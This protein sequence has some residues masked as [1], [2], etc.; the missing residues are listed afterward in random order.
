[1]LPV[2]PVPHTLGMTAVQRLDARRRRMLALHGSTRQVTTPQRLHSGGSQ[3]LPF[4]LRSLSLLASLCA[5]PGGVPP[6]LPPAHLRLDVRRRRMALPGFCF[7]LRLRLRSCSSLCLRLS[8]SAALALALAHVFDTSAIV[9]TTC[10]G[11]D[12]SGGPVLH[13]ALFTPAPV[14]NASSLSGSGLRLD[15][16]RGTL[17]LCLLLTLT[18]A[19]ALALLTFT[20]QPRRLCLCLFFPSPTLRLAALLL[21]LQLEAALLCCVATCASACHSLNV[22]SRC[23]TLHTFTFTLFTLTLFTFTCQPCRLCLFFLLPSPTLRLAALLLKLQLEAALFG[24]VTTCVS[25]CHSLNAHSR[26][27]NLV[28]FGTFVVLLFLKV[29]VPRIGV[30]KSFVGV[31]IIVVPIAS[32]LTLNTVT[33]LC[34]CR[35]CFCFTPPTLFRFFSTPPAP[36]HRHLK[37]PL[38]L[39][40]RSA[41]SGSALDAN[42]CPPLL[43]SQRSGAP[44]LFLCFRARP[45]LSRTLRGLLGATLLFFSPLTGII[46][47][48]GLTT[49]RDTLNAHRRQ[50]VLLLLQRVVQLE[51]AAPSRSAPFL[52]FCFRLFLLLPSQF[53]QALLLLCFLAQSSLRFLRLS[54]LLPSKISET[55]P[56]LSFLAQS[57]C[58]LLLRLLL[59]SKILQ[60]LPLP[61]TLCFSAQPFCLRLFLLLPSNILQALPLS[62]FLPCTFC[63]RLLFLSFPS[64]LRQ[65]LSLCFFPSRSFQL[66]T[67]TFVVL[68]PRLL[69]LF[70]N[71]PPRRP[72]T[73]NTLHLRGTRVA[74]CIKLTLLSHLP[75][76]TSS[77]M[78]PARA[79]DVNGTGG[80]QLRSATPLVSKPGKAPQGPYLDGHRGFVTELVLQ[81]LALTLQRLALGSSFVVWHGQRAVIHRC[82]TGVQVLEEPNGVDFCGIPADVKTK[83]GN[84]IVENLH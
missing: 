64:K 56:L 67:T 78:A 15:A 40:T 45:L 63:V 52:L 18:F 82:A 41:L 12:A 3:A 25:A 11:L 51:L 26:C 73:R 27:F 39:R 42:C 81:Q 32:I 23:F 59:P 31:P 16:H 14:C 83:Q 79:L 30:V 75:H 53:R 37:Q 4:T 57:F 28:C 13:F 38:A 22:H 46:L 48:P 47:A 44:L 43:L 55:L 70:K 34:L 80:P 60:A 20:C 10:G 19:L 76:L 24:C 8:S 68:M 66:T 49:P 62:F 77:Q 5:S 29:A 71:Q 61:C 6:C 2:L 21:K 84:T 36:G 72:T 58:F 7:C 65:A 17:S 50:S 74:Q 33:F 69:L 35:L 9:M 54:F 1:M